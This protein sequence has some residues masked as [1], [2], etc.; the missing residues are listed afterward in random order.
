MDY[1]CLFQNW[2]AMSPFLAISE[3]VVRFS[4]T[5]CLAGSYDKNGRRRGQV[6]RAAQL[7]D[8]KSRLGFA[9]RRLENSHCKP[10]SEWVHFSNQGRL[11]QRKERD[12]LRLSSAVPKIQWDSNPPPPPPP[13][14][15]PLPPTAIRLRETFTFM[16]KT[17]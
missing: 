15:P 2:L 1:R 10:I 5:F 14:P 9:M 4:S 7:W 3:A 12:G 17:P 11:R 16:I 8:R 6:V 13:P